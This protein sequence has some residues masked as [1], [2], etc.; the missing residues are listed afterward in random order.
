MKLKT[1]QDLEFPTNLWSIVFEKDLS[2]TD[3]PPDWAPT[4]SY[5]LDALIPAKKG[6]ILLAFYRDG[7][8]LGEI[9]TEY[10]VCRERVRQILA[11]SIRDL[12]HPTLRWIMLYGLKASS[13]ISGVR[14]DDGTIPTLFQPPGAPSP[15]S[16]ISDLDLSKRAYHY[17]TNAG[18]HT[19]EDL[20][21]RTESDLLHIPNFGM[22]SLRNVKAN[23]AQYGYFLAAATPDATPV[24]RTLQIP[25]DPGPTL[26]HEEL[27]TL[28]ATILDLSMENTR[29]SSLLAETEAQLDRAML[30]VRHLQKALSEAVFSGDASSAEPTQEQSALDDLS[31][32]GT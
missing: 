13:H 20:T 14:T 12:R 15:Q 25:E 5:V 22:A 7:K 4:L 2:P 9:G 16:P 6:A 21:H 31:A 29:L 28:R 1:R 30:E 17:L 27:S 11:Q 26:P 24:E 19:V 23:L 8:K 10:D 32:C 18:I 3:L